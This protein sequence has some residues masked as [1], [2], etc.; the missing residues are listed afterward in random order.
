MLLSNADG[1]LLCKIYVHD[2]V[3]HEQVVPIAKSADIGLCLIQNISLSDYFC[4]PNKLFEYSFSGLPVLASR[5]PDISALV[6][7]YNL[8]ICCDLD[9]KSIYRAIKEFEVL[10]EFP[11]IDTNLLYELSWGAQEKK[12]LELYESIIIKRGQ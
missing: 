4:L 8:G 9:S 10:G 7:K 6:K 1:R 2:A 12:L 5:F 11:K 3:A